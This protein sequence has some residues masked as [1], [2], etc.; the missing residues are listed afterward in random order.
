MFIKPSD[1]PWWAWL[2]WALVFAVVGRFAFVGFTAGAG[3]LLLLLAI[4][5]GLLAIGCSFVGI[6]RFVRWP[7]P[8]ACRGSKRAEHFLVGFDLPNISN[9]YG[10]ERV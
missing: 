10:P 7:E 5:C 8:T 4:A 2:G 3:F 6:I 1:L 9:I